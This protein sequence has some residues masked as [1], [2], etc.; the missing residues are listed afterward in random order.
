MPAEHECLEWKN[1][2]LKPQNQGVHEGEGI[3]NVKN[4]TPN[5]AGVF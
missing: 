1:Q 2:C 3:H 4:D 5:L